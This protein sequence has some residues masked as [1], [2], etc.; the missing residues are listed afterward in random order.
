M[1]TLWKIS[2]LLL[3]FSCATTRKIP[4]APPALNYFPNMKGCFLLYNLKSKA[5]EKVLGDESYCRERL[6]ACSTFKVPLAVMAFDAG[7]LKDEKVVLK[8]DG[9]KDPRTELNHDHNAVTWMRDS[10]VW[11]SQ[12]LTPQLGKVKLQK[13]L[14]SFLYGNR[15]LSAG[16]QWA[17]LMAPSEAAALKISAYEQVEFM[18][19][20]WSNSLPVSDRAMALTRE[21]T[22]LESSPNGFQLNGKT[23][24]NFYD[25]DKKVALGWFIAHLDNG[26]VRRVNSQK[27]HQDYIVVT[28]ISD[29]E[30][31]EEPGYG[32]L[33]AKTLTK[34]ILA[35]EGLW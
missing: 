20:L 17:W 32:G 30:P 16:L 27:K 12:R 23:G 18:K 34:K 4:E 8:W 9:V 6:P 24:S 2:P 10:V 3:I 21:I 22:Y 11:F 26:F 14:D 7:V 35:D 13:Y 19:K 25:K 5:F 31:S 29:L 28:T 15:D 33:R 1:R